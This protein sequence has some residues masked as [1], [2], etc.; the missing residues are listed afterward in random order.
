MTTTCLN[1]TNLLTP[2]QYIERGAITIADGKISYAGPM[3]SAPCTG[4]LALDLRGKYVIPGLFDIHVH[5][6][7]GVS[8]GETDDAYTELQTYSKWVASHGVTH[9]L[10][11]LA[12]PDEE[13]LIEK[14]GAFVDVLE[15]GVEGAQP[16]GVHLEGPYLNPRKKGA[17]NPTWLREPQV[18]EVEALLKAGR[19]WIRQV[20]MAPELKNAH[21][22]AACF[23]SAGVVVALGHTDTD[24]ESACQ[25]LKGNF[26]HVTHTFNAQSGFN[27]RQPGVFGAVLNSDEVTAELIAD[28]IHVHP[29]AMKVLIRCLGSD[30]VVLI[31]D[32]MSGAGLPDG[33][34]DLIGENVTVSGG[35][36]T[37]PDGTIAGSTM[38]LNQGVRN[39]HQVV[40]VPFA[41]AVKM[42]TLN[43]ARAMGFS[44]RL[45]SLSVGKEANLTVV[46][47][48][49]NVYLTMVKGNVAYNNL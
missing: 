24:Y 30:R 18:K 9:Y 21:E 38:L 6:G 16:L 49:M 44:D 7:K 41:D 31:T 43:P 36:A 48:E 17:F 29:G 42:A 22:A 40:G 10:V 35:R 2:T 26:T 15:E 28:T 46:D 1:Y 11:S 14:L 25:A 23:R 39:V 4:G 5:G 12:A 20:T 8:F 27:H 3:E 32:A 34:Y 33:V 45:G 13:A 47:E 19:G 37:L